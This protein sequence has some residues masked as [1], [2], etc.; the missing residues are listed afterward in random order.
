M[1]LALVGFVPASIY[2]TRSISITTLTLP[3]TQSNTLPRHEE[4]TSRPI[5]LHSCCITLR[6][7][8]VLHISCNVN[9]DL[10]RKI[11]HLSIFGGLAQS[12]DDTSTV[13]W[14]GLRHPS[15]SLPPPSASQRPPPDLFSAS[16]FTFGT[17]TNLVHST[18]PCRNLINPESSRERSLGAPISR[19]A[20]ARSVAA[21]GRPTT[22]SETDSRA[23]RTRPF[24]SKEEGDGAAKISRP[25]SRGS[26]PAS[27]FRHGDAGCRQ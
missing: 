17:I 23:G 10:L 18:A 15:H 12:G 4:T 8:K 27:V 9:V 11:A 21:S 20:R 22:L 19:R 26:W 14:E 3:S 7:Y 1:I 24:V 6:L 25:L 16:D 2:L 13:I 5:V